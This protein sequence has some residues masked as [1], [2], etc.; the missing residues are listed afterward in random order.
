MAGTS[1]LA[2]TGKSF[3]WDALDRS[4]FA[5]EETCVAGLLADAPL[6]DSQRQGAVRRGREL[7]EIARKQARRRGMVE[8][9][10]EEFGLTNQEGLSLMCLAEALLR[11]PDAETRDD[12]IAE[13]I[14]SGDWGAHKGQS[15]SWL[16]NAS[17]WGL[18][19]TGKVIG[20]GRDALKGPA[21]LVQGLVRESGEPVIRAAMMQAMRIMG[22]QFV[23]GRNVK[24]ALK[25]GRKMVTSGDAAHF[26]FD[27]LGEGARTM[28]DAERYL[29][30][31]RDAVDAVGQDRPETGAPEHVNGVA[32][33][34]SALHPRYEAVNTDRVMAELYPR[35]L[36]L[37][38]QARDYRINLCL[39]AEEADRLALSLKLL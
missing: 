26:S 3:D 6:T 7:V 4:K 23:L 25:R 31:Y 1:T 14:R 9:F 39:D 13:K 17:T 18:M 12:L 38:E 32:V 34:L 20:P 24:A 2:K 37:C 10:L 5:D 30:A 21:A 36:G 16:V 35:L 8:S 19:L 22:E 27:M 33:K 15:D 11:V 29:T 28:A